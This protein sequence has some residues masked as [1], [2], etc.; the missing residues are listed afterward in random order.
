M[1]HCKDVLKFFSTKKRRVTC[2]KTISK[3]TKNDIIEQRKKLKKEEPT[4]CGVCLKE[5]DDNDNE[6][7]DWI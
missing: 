6:F 5:N 7:V 3:L 1:A 4:I 2:T